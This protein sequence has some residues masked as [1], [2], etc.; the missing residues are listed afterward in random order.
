[1][2]IPVF[3]L[4]RA[5]ELMILLS[6]Y[7]DRLEL[8]VP[9]FFSAGMAAR[10]NQYYRFFVQ[11][12]N[13]AVRET[14]VEKNIFNFPRIKT[15]DIRSDINH[16]GACV[17]LA[18]PGMLHA[19][20]SLR[21][22]KTWCG[23]PKNLIVLPGYC[24]PKTVGG[25]VLAG[26]KEVKIDGKTYQVQMQVSN[27]S[28][29]AHADQAGIMRLIRQVQP[30]NV[31]LVHGEPMKMKNLYNKITQEIGVDCQYPA[32][33][34]IAEFECWPHQRIP[35]ASQLATN[36]RRNRMKRR[37]VLSRLCKAF[38]SCEDCP[39]GWFDKAK[40][41]RRA[42]DDLSEAL[43][44]TTLLPH[45]TLVDEGTVRGRLRLLG[46]DESQE[47]LGKERT[48]EFATHMCHLPSKLRRPGAQGLEY[49]H[50]SLSRNLSDEYEVAW[51]DAPSESSDQA[52]TES[53]SILVTNPVGGATCQV[54]LG[55]PADPKGH[56]SLNLRLE[57]TAGQEDF[58]GLVQS[59]LYL[60]CDSYC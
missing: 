30:K 24:V 44:P 14:F 53:R 49:V 2:L 8:D 5:Q 1:M 38:P 35:V 23:N 16:R 25:Q 42:K 45:A 50:D 56:P 3:A 58:A 11:W 55:P 12:C 28:F 13:Q 43:K 51:R 17:L 21:V 19:G 48:V 57:Y 46:K 26:K 52:S 6:E 47:F 37:R 10:A 40:K 20:T 29:S 32:N 36:I 31:M 60:S 9:I 27:L 15:F 4:G 22:F 39:G 54:S 33:L 7:W 59:L 34:S 41:R 18:T